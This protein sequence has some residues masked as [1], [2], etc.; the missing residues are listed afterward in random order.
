MEQYMSKTR[1]NYGSGVVM[2]KINDK[3]YFEL[4]GQYLKELHK[5][6]FS[7]FKH[8]D[9]NEHIKKVL[10][11]I[12]LFHILEVTQD[13]VMLR[14]FPMSLT[15]AAS[16]WLRNEPSEVL[17]LIN[18][19][20]A[21]QTQLNNLEREI[22][23]VNEKVYAAQVRCELCK[24]SHYTK[25]YPLKEEGNTLEEAYYTSFR[26][27]YQPSGQYRG[28]GPGFYQR[29]NR[30]SLYPDRRQTLEE[31]LTKFMVLSSLTM[32]QKMLC[33]AS[34]LHEI[35]VMPNNY[36]EIRSRGQIV[37]VATLPLPKPT[38][39]ARLMTMAVPAHMAKKR[40]ALAN[41]TNQRPRNGSNLLIP[42]KEDEENEFSSSV[43]SWEGNVK[44]QK[45]M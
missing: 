38:V 25:D 10:E 15:R 35:R 3:T 11:I 21:I 31:S 36:D 42:G 17:K 33:L 19:L 44:D 34:I 14:V 43:P 2:A 30:N 5:N 9:A 6:T 45:Y 4:K 13:Q 26:T 29:N 37:D 28:A 22:K 16:R 20:A 12:V 32:L 41:V 7:G 8:E 40:H 18:E 1:G 23:K 24:G 39:V 27:P